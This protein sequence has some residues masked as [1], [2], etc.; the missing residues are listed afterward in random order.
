MKKIIIIGAGAR[1]I[2]KI[3]DALEGEEAVFISESFP[4]HSLGAHIVDMHEEEEAGIDNF[5][6]SIPIPLINCVIDDFNN[7]KVE[8]EKKEHPFKKF[9][10]KKRNF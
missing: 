3:K 8:P 9:I 4:Q 5:K 2:Q 7:V 1:Q 10:K 6:F